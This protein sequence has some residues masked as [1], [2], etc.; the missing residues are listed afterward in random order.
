MVKIRSG[1]EELKPAK[2]TKKTK[3]LDDKKDK[4]ADKSIAK[5]R[6]NKKVKIENKNKITRYFNNFNDKNVIKNE[7]KSIRYEEDL[8]ENV[9]L[10]GRLVEKGGNEANSSQA[11]AKLSDDDWEPEVC[12]SSEFT[13][14]VVP[15]QGTLKTRAI[16]PHRG[17]LLNHH[18]RKTHVTLWSQARMGLVLVSKSWRQILLD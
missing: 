11:R 14:G 5:V 8:L 6:M 18:L 3:K 13:A 4:K 7:V 1:F 12:R 16:S 10:A 15:V 9:E 2:V 17:E